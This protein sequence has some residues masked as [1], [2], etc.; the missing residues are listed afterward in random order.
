MRIFIGRSCQAG[1]LFVLG[2]L[3]ANTFQQRRLT[4]RGGF[5]RIWV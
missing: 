5:L 2:L 4:M 1:A 3:A